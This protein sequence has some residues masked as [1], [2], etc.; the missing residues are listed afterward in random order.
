V[1]N[2]LI[3]KEFIFAASA[4]LVNGRTRTYTQIRM[5]IPMRT[6]LVSL[7]LFCAHA[8][9]EPPTM[10]IR[11]LLL[12]GNDGKS[13]PALNDKDGKPQQWRLGIGG[14]CS[15]TDP[16]KHCWY[17]IM[18][19]SKPYPYGGAMA[20]FD[21]T[22]QAQ[23]LIP[24]TLLSISIDRRLGYTKYC[25]PATPSHEPL[26]PDVPVE[27]REFKIAEI[28][29]TG[30]VEGNT[31]NSH[32]KIQPQPGTLTIFMRRMTWAEETAY[33]LKRQIT[34]QM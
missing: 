22:G 1:E 29:A 30:I 10:T 3:A 13:L 19:P 25:Q 7:L 16:S 26:A 11:I 24:D 31:C 12:N 28:Q 6:L 33:K 18:G 8:D 27:D 14:N 23:P 20:T 34:P 5:N 2:R 15:H 4:I 21:S 17:D 32:L 9:A